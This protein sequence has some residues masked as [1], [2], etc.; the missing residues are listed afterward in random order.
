MEVGNLVQLSPHYK[1]RNRW[2][3]ITKMEPHSAYCEITFMD[4]REIA[5]TI[6]SALVIYEN[7]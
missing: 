3:V 2:A 4:T 1:N 6:K 7:R 5:Y